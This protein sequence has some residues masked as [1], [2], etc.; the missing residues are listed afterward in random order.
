MTA[1]SYC[2][3]TH[4]ALSGE[5]L[6][7]GIDVQAK[8]E[9][10]GP[11]LEIQAVTRGFFPREGVGHDIATIIVNA[12]AHEFNLLG[13]KEGGLVRATTSLFQWI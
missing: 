9:G 12:L 6:S 10:K 11:Q 4:S 13:R 1:L 7:A 8:H 5:W 3:G 2:I